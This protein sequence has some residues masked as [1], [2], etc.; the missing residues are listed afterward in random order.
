MLA[1]P[2]PTRHRSTCSSIVVF[3]NPQWDCK[4]RPRP[5]LPVALKKDDGG[6]DRPRHPD[7]EAVLQARR[8]AAAVPRLVR[9]QIGADEHRRLLRAVVEGA[10]RQDAVDEVVRL[11]MVPGM[12]HCSGGDGTDTFDALGRARAMGRA[13][14]PPARIVASRAR[15]GVVERT[16][17]LCAYPQVARYTGQGSTDDERNFSCAER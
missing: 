6:I 14:Q 12:A 16:R 4:V 5:R 2:E 1:G 11:F 17:P 8:Q 15:N 13:P 7:S 9:S 3:K 10:R